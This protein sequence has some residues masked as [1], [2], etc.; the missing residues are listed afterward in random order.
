MKKIAALCSAF[1]IPVAPHGNAHMNIHAVAS[2]S[3][4]IIL[5]TYP[6]KARDFNPA[7]PAFPVKDGMVDAHTAIGLGM[8]PDPKLVKKYRV[9]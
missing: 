7:L 2:I 1:H 5:E 6:A 4:A 8:E 9:E 3:N